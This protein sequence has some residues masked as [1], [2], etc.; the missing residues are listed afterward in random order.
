[1]NVGQG[2][3]A[4]KGDFR[5]GTSTEGRRTASAKS[6]DGETHLRSLRGAGRDAV[7]TQGRRGILDNAFNQKKPSGRTEG[8][9]QKVAD[10]RD[11]GKAFN[12]SRSRV[13][14]NPVR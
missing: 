12:V 2:S 11:H 9:K 10:E 8:A 4:K 1:V 7:S 6:H 5:R 13:G 3:G 14:G